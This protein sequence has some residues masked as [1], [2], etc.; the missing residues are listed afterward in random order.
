MHTIC[1]PARKW[2]EPQA[3]SL[4]HAVMLE[5]AIAICGGYKAINHGSLIWQHAWHEWCP[6]RIYFSETI[7]LLY[8]LIIVITT[9]YIHL[10]TTHMYFIYI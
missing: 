1:G 3:Q 2:I 8:I 7:E 5:I 4:V 10:F 9:I 6:R